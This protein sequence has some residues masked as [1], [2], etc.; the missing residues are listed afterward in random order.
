MVKRKKWWWWDMK[1]AQNEGEC[2]GEIV[3]DATAP[4]SLAVSFIALSPCLARTWPKIKPAMLE[5]TNKSLD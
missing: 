1:R 5:K 3:A 4:T 2:S